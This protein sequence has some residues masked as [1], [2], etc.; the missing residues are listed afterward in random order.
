MCFVMIIIVMFVIVMVIAVDSVIVVNN[1]TSI[2][3]RM[4]ATITI[5]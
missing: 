1:V 5:T 4:G 2:T 3:I